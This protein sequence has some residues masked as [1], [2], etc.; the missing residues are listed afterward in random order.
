VIDVGEEYECQEDEPH[1]QR[2][3]LVKRKQTQDQALEKDD[4]ESA[5]E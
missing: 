5:E 4:E 3:T 1:L 2:E